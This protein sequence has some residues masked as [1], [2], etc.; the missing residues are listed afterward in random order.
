MRKMGKGKISFFEIAAVAFVSALF[1]I[2]SK[3]RGETALFLFFSL[4]VI[5]GLPGTYPGRRGG[6]KKGCGHSFS[7]VCGLI[8]SV[9]CHM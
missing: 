3:N 8:G 4:A 5:Y 9:S 1:L 7:G 2:F 6:R